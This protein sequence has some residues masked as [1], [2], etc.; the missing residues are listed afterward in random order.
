[1]D[2]ERPGSAPLP[3]TLQPSSEPAGSISPQPPLDLSGFPLAEPW[4]ILSADA[5]ADAAPDFVHPLVTAAHLDPGAPW[6]MSRI[7]PAGST[8]TPPPLDPAGFPSPELWTGPH[9]DARPDAASDPSLLP[10]AAACLDPTDVP[11]TSMTNPAGSTPTPPPL[12][13]AGFPSPELWT[14]P[15]MVTPPDAA[16]DPALPPAAAA[17]LDLTDVPPTSKTNP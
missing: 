8:P 1:M 17:C 13:S 10:V 9:M 4:D 2:P 6:L 14:G 3:C 5:P 7:N 11:P 16:I 12:D 15:H